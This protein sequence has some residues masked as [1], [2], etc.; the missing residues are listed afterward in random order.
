M[1]VPLEIVLRRMPGPPWA[2]EFF[3]MDAANI[4]RSKDGFRRNR[5][6]TEPLG[7]GLVLRN[8]NY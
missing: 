4:R 3:R 5:P 7:H 1:L 6:A 8:A 2:G